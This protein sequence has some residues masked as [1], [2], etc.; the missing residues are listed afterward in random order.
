MPG[1][2]TVLSPGRRLIVRSP[3]SG[4]TT[5]WSSVTA[6]IGDY[7]YRGDDPA[8]YMDVFDQEAGDEDD[9]SAFSLLHVPIKR[10]GS[11]KR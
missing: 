2:R 3:Q 7:S 4:G 10:K 6:T 9:A 1:S 8:S 5:T 11:R